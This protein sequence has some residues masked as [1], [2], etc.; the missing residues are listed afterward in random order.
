LRSTKIDVAL[1]GM[2]QTNRRNRQRQRCGQPLASL[3]P[4]FSHGLTH[5]PLN[6][7]LSGDAELFEQLSDARVEDVFLHRAPLRSLGYLS[8]ARRPIKKGSRPS[9]SLIARRLIA[10]ADNEARLGLDLPN[11]T[12]SEPRRAVLKG[13]RVALAARPDDEA[14]WG[15]PQLRQPARF[16]PSSALDRASGA[17]VAGQART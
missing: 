3:Q 11:L 7:A 8:L 10:L 4:M 14:H 2:C 12:P 9:A 5:R 17:G 1:Y 13:L 15:S 16:V 6:L